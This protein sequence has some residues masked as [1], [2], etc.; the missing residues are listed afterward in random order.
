MPEARSDFSVFR[1]FLTGSPILMAY[2]PVAFAVGVLAGQT[3]FSAFENFCLFAFVFS[4]SGQSLALQLLGLGQP[5]LAI[6]STTAV[7]N[8][9]Y[10]LFSATLAPWLSAWPRLFR[11]LNCLFIVDETFAIQAAQFN[12]E[13][14]PPRFILAANLT[15]YLAWVFGGVMGHLAGD[16]VHDV[17]PFGFDFAIP[18]MFIALVAMQIEDRLLVGLG[19]A[20]A[21]LGILFKLS[22]FADW[23][24]LL[25][26]VLCATLATLGVRW[27]TNYC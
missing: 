6:L 25:A 3:G 23:A 4:G 19:V 7:I 2:L 26:G 13:M 11:Y 27:K 1:G 15:A 20:G 12:R 5:I 17:K 21:A 22:P 8:L 24:V 16:L 14:P 9:R 18:A 10:F